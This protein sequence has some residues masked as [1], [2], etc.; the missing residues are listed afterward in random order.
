MAEGNGTKVY[1][2]GT[3]HKMRQTDYPLPNEYY[4]AYNNSDILVTDVDILN[5]LIYI[6]LYYI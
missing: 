3:I 1:I 5:K 6:K 2:G 4:R